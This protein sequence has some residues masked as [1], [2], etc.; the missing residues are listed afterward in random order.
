MSTSPYSLDLRK[1]LISYLENKSTQ[2]SAAKLFGLNISTVSRWWNRYKRENTVEARVRIGKKPTI[3]I[4]EFKEYIEL[5]PNLNSE[6][7]GKYF[8]MTSGG[9]L[10]WLKKLGYTYKKKALPM[11][12]QIKNKENNMKKL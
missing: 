9:A 2:V 12:K 11:W 1:K 3:D 7:I 4:K 8:G 6:L 5:N 10:Y